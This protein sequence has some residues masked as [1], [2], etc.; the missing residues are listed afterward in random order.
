MSRIATYTRKQVDPLNLQPDDVCIEDIAHALSMKCRYS[1]HTAEFYSVAQHCVIAADA[2]CQS[3]PHLALTMLL[4]DAAE[5]YIPDF[6]RPVKNRFH[7]YIHDSIASNVSRLETDLLRT[8]CQGLGLPNLPFS[9]TEVHYMDRVMLKTEKR[10]LW[11]GL[12]MDWGDDIESCMPLAYSITPCSAQLA[13]SEFLAM[14]EYL[15][16]AAFSETPQL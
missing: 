8:I 11:P 1:G 3:I 9:T 4:H 5:A 12:A 2:M 7:V 10:D 16:H 6:A 14:Y 13:E 15:K